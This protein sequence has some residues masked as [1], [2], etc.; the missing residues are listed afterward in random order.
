MQLTIDGGSHTINANNMGPVF[1]VHSG[2]VAIVNLRI[3][4]ARARGGNGG[5]S[6]WGGVVSTCE[7]R[8]L[9]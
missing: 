2:T 7:Q 1:F 8:C 3:M 4:N 6:T 9:T 5:L